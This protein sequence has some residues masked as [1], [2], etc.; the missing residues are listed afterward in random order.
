MLEKLVLIT[1][2][3]FCLMMIVALGFSLFVHIYI[4]KHKDKPLSKEEWKIME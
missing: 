4:W 1:L 2:L 3:V